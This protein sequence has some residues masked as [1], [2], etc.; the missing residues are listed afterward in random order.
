MLQIHEQECDVAEGVDPAQIG[1]EFDAVEGCDLIFKQCDVT[2]VE[3]TMA[4]AD[5]ACIVALFHDG[6]QNHAL[7]LGPGLQDIQ[8][9]DFKQRLFQAPYE[10][11]VLQNGLN[12]MLRG[13]VGH[14]MTDRGYGMMEVRKQAGQVLDLFS[15]RQG[16]TE[17]ILL[18]K[19]AHFYGILNDPLIRTDSG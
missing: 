15:V 7:L 13:A 5:M 6:L 16:V 18:A 3:V 4:F 19:P 11:K 12:D 17:Q 8:S 14:T 9:F 2:Q 1:I 10:P